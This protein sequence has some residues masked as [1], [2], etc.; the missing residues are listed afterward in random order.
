MQLDTLIFDPSVC[1]FPP[2]RIP[3]LPTG[4]D[5]L[6]L[7]APG[8]WSPDEHFRHY[9]RGRYALTQ[10]FRFAGIGPEATLLA[11]SYHCRT[12]LDPALA[13]QGRVALYPLHADLSPDIAAI[14]A[15]AATS[16]P[17]PAALL[18]TH[19]FG[20]PQD[21]STLARWCKSRSIILIEDASHALFCAQHHPAGIG[22]FGDFVVS[23]PYKF[24]PSP[25]GGLLWI[26][27]PQGRTAPHPHAPGWTAEL[28]GIKHTLDA[29]RRSRKLRYDIERLHI[30]LAVILA[31]PVNCAHEI[32][33]P[34]GPSP[35]YR[36][37]SET[38]AAL[39][40]S[41]LVQR[42][43]D[44][45]DIARRRRKNYRH[46]CEGLSGIQ[47]CRPLFAALPDQSIPYMLPLLID[48]PDPHFYYLKHLGMP[49][50]RWDSVATSTCRVANDYRLR[51]LHLPCHQSLSD[52]QLDWM[53]EAVRL[54]VGS[55]AVKAPT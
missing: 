11:P 1:G 20:I 39:R 52:I 14:E 45:D 21:F 32:R 51:L 38:V 53:I 29:A 28:R 24:S 35:S 30:E 7:K 4:L 54:V 55:T 50:W 34:E 42:H 12:M 23:S 43:A 48:M 18:A 10:A 40:I 3:L 47:H 13:L 17:R 19:F 27:H 8:Q 33:R 16:L 15:L 25:D 46:L 37:R 26:R 6:T 49:I 36:H 31:K 22:T 5:C 2:P 41:R 9:S 44:I